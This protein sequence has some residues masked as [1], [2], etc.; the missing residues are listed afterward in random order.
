MFR[1]PLKSVL[2]AL[3]KM[4]ELSGLQLVLILVYLRKDHFVDNVVVQAT[5]TCNPGVAHSPM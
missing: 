3:V 5:G 4:P 2:D 1:T